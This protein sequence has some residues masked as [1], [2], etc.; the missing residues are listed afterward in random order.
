MSLLRGGAGADPSPQ[1]C[2]MAVTPCASLPIWTLLVLFLFVLLVLFFW[3][4]SFFFKF[5]F[6]L[7][8]LV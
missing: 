1:A 4:L 6:I 5:F 8:V 2:V 7:V 3:L